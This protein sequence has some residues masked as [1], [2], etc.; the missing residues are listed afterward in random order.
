MHR[1]GQFSTPDFPT[2][3]PGVALLDARIRTIGPW[4]RSPNDH[5]EMHQPTSDELV[6]DLEQAYWAWDDAWMN[7]LRSRAQSLGV[8]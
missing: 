1:H 7:W 6:D 3:D 2:L 5:G 8:E 4:R